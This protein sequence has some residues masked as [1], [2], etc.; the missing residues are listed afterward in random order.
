MGSFYAV[1][2][3]GQRARPIFQKFDF[4]SQNI[5]HWQMVKMAN[6]LTHHTYYTF[7]VD[8][9]NYFCG[10]LFDCEWLA[11]KWQGIAHR[12]RY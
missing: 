2:G 1:F 3:A 5:R 7:S 9:A 10:F 8:I 4:I 6:S 11:R 12:A